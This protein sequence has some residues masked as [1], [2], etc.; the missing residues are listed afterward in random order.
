MCLFV[1]SD[2]TLDFLN[3]SDGKWFGC[4]KWIGHSKKVFEEAFL[5]QGIEV[6]LEAACGT[7]FAL[8]SWAGDR[9][10]ARM[11]KHREHFISKGQWRPYDGVL[12]L[13]GY[14]DAVPKNRSRYSL[15]LSEALNETL[16]ECYAFVEKPPR[17]AQQ[18]PLEF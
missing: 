3:Y 9:F 2:S 12:I 6:V 17:S 15:P 8:R 4:G 13:G 18:L 10:G 14:N 16:I 11:K 1:L 5:H 7:G